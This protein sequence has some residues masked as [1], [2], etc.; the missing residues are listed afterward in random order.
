MGSMARVNGVGDQA[1]FATD[2]L[3]PRPLRAPFRCAFRSPS[4]AAPP[5][6]PRAP[7]D[8][9]PIPAESGDDP[10]TRTHAMLRAAATT[11]AWDAFA[12]AADAEYPLATLARFLIVHSGLASS[13]DLDLAS[14][15][16]FLLA[17]DIA[18][19]APS[20]NPAVEIGVPRACYSRAAPA[21]PAANSRTPPAVGYHNVDH[22]AS[23]STQSVSPSSTSAACASP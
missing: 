7:R 5:A 13:L 2:L 20:V 19:A 4:E 16:R 18:Y 14:L 22:A 1:G 8:V 3:P 12:Y 10:I 11:W 17:I 9:V 21:A 15:D 6:F 23:T